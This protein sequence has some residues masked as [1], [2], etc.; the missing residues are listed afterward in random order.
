M[1]VAWVVPGPQFD[2]VDTVLL[3]LL[4]NL[5]QV[6]GGEQG[7]KD[8]DSHAIRDKATTAQSPVFAIPRGMGNFDNMRPDGSR[9]RHN[10]HV[11]VCRSREQRSGLC[12]PPVRP[13]CRMERGGELSLR[14][15]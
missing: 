8:A 2:G 12:S 9:P 14:R 13:G 10:H 5:I 4:Q 15:W 6:K 7:G 11:H 1:R 3:K